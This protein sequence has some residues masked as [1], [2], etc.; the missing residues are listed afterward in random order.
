MLF[1]KLVLV[2]VRSIS[3]GFFINKNLE[4]LKNRIDLLIKNNLTKERNY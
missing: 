1:D 4:M 2:A 3:Y